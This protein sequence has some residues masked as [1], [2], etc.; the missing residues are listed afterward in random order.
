MSKNQTQDAITY[1]QP[2]IKDVTDERTVKLFED[3]NLM[4]V[5]KFLRSQPLGYMTAKEIEAKFKEIN[6]EKSDKTV[7]RYLKKLENA[8]LVIQAGKRVFPT[9][10]KKLKTQTLYMRTA[11]IFFPKTKSQKEDSETDRCEKEKFVQAIG[12]LVGKHLGIKTKS[13]DCLM[14]FILQIKDYQ[15]D[16]F[17]KLVQDSNEEISDL[18]TSFDWNDIE[19]LSSIVVLLATISDKKDWLIQMNECFEKGP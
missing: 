8:E 11:K 12:I 16:L 1:S 10:K 19:N 14:N 3:E 4:Q 15:S 18:L 2:L 17:R 5:L 6:K 13:V 9:K 7:Y